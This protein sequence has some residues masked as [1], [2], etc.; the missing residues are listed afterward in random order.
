MCDNGIRLVSKTGAPKGV[1]SSN[2]SVSSKLIGPVVK[3][4]NTQD[5]GSCAERFEGSNPSGT[6]IEF[7]K[8]SGG[9]IIPYG[10]AE[11]SDPDNLEL[12]FGPVVELIDTQV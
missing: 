11:M 6:T 1:E 10:M 8:E 12:I 9:N 5:L 4:V 7:M 3:L 2:L